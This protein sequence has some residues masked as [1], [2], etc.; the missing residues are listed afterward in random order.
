MGV[1]IATR[2]PLIMV[3]VP[4][5]LVSMRLFEIAAAVLA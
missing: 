5:L 2:L 3:F 4:T 1:T